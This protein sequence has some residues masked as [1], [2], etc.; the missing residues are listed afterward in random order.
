VSQCKA[1]Q[2]ARGRYLGGSLPFGFRCGESGEL[3]A[4]G[5]EQQAIGEMMALR[6]QGMALRAIAS[7][8]WAKG[9]KVSHE[10]VRAALMARRTESAKPAAPSISAK[11][12]KRPEGRTP[13]TPFMPLRMRS[14]R[15][16]ANNLNCRFWVKSKPL[17]F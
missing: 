10:G 5:A 12:F 2:K 13:E 9:V 1:D 8:M 6:A 15:S 16:P 17:R 14:F 3:V 7:A 11:F 4:V